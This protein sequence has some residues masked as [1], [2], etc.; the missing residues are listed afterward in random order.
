MRETQAGLSSVLETPS[1]LHGLHRSQFPRIEVRTARQTMRFPS[2]LSVFST[3][4]FKSSQL[5]GNVRLTYQS[6]HLAADASTP[7]PQRK[8]NPSPGRP[9]GPA[10]LRTPQHLSPPAAPSRLLRNP[11]AS[12]PARAH[13]PPTCASGTAVKSPLLYHDFK[14]SLWLPN[15][16]QHLKLCKSLYL[17]NNKN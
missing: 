8:G 6:S 2:Q 3:S 10:Q 17:K 7:I 15:A 5:S 1:N 14:H 16:H 9:P 11:R 13:G 12:A 4:W